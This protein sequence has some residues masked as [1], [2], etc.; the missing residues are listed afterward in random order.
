MELRARWR[1]DHRAPSEAAELKRTA[2]RHQA[3]QACCV[4]P[5]VKKGT[6]LK[7]HLLPLHAW[8]ALPECAEVAFR[9]C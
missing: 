4:F 5:P 8:H 3:A 9:D 6:A 7:E 1:A 2:A